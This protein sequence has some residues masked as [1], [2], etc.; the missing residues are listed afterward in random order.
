[1]TEFDKRRHPRTD[2]IS[3][4]EYRVA[5]SGEEYFDGVVANV[6]KSGFCLFAM[7]SLHKD[8]IITI[9]DKSDIFAGTAVVRW[10]KQS[11]KAPYI[12]G[13]EFR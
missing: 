5:P 1:M 2:K 9:K 10:S 4:I 6:S 3:I 8:D 11:E 7:S 13:L 12:A